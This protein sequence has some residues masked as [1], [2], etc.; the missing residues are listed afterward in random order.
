MTGSVPPGF[1]AMLGA[2]SGFEL[3]NGM[4]SEQALQ[5]DDFGYER[6]G[7]SCIGFSRRFVGGWLL[8]C[9]SKPMVVGGG[10]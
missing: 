10:R 2:P 7:G 8:R 4:G 1:A 3:R 6:A 9:T 5:R